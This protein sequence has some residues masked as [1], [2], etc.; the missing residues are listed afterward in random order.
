MKSLSLG[1]CLFL[2]VSVC[3]ATKTRS[4]KAPRKVVPLSPAV[5]EQREA[6][7]KKTLCAFTDLDCGY[8]RSLF[9][10][11][12]FQ[13]YQPPPP[14]PPPQNPGPKNHE[15]NPYLATRFGLLTPESLER[16]RA[17]INQYYSAFEAALKAYG[18]PE[19]VLCGHLRIETNFG[20]PTSLTLHPLGTAPA[21]NRLVTLYVRRTTRKRQKFAVTQ[22]RDLI[23]AAIKNDWD[24]FDVPGSSTGAIGLL[25]FEPSNFYIAVDG[26]GD[27][28][29]DLFDPADAIMS[30]AHFLETHGYDGN[31]QHQ[32]KAIYSYY[33]KDPHKYYMKAVLAYAA[34]E[35]SYLKEHPALFAPPLL[36]Q[37]LPLTTFQL[38]AAEPAPPAG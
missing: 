21:F 20:M 17:F 36:T 18:V 2:S 16:C 13:L 12:R 30:L 9:D 37:P 7:L 19:G 8:V 32:Q 23:A 29:I 31:P 34:A 1:L 28:K 22:L 14:A 10:A 35:N 26:D 15:R 6:T 25:Q 33:G 4:V 3:A 27:G 11:P 24:L 38:N 5:E